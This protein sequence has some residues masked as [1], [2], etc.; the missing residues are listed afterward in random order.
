MDSVRAHE[1]A[2]INAAANTGVWREHEVKRPRR[3]RAQVCETREEV[4]G[5]MYSTYSGSS[6]GEGGVQ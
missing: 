4:D 3:P 2:P 1:R 6:G 5:R